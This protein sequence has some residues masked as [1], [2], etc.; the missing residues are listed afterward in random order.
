MHSNTTKKLAHLD[1]WRNKFQQ[2]PRNTQN[3][4]P[5]MIQEIQN[6][7]L[8][9]TSIVI[10]IRHDHQVAVPQ[11]LCACICL[12]CLQSHDLFNG[13]KGQARMSAMLLLFDKQTGA[14]F[15]T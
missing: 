3:A 2:E 11:R 14:G 4:G 13:A 1:N 12:A 10:L 5:E 9:V 15:L 6:Q 7:S 8:D